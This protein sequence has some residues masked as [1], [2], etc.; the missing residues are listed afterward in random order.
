MRR[1]VLALSLLFPGAA[2]AQSPGLPYTYPVTVGTSSSQA[3]GTNA[4]RRRIEF[5]NSSDTAKIAV[6]PTISRTV[7]QTITCTVNGPGSI[8]LLP[9]QSYRVDG[10]GGTPQVNSAWNAIASA[11]GSS[12]TVFEWE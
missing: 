7:T 3:I 5:Y 4:A 6:C 9:Y 11:G 10:V 8:T 1:L 12:L 2:Y